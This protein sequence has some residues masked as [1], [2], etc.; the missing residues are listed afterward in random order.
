MRTKLFLGA[1][2]LPATFLSAAADF[3]PLKVKPGLWQVT[4]NNNL[5]GTPHTLTY[6]K[7]ITAKD[8]NTNPWGNGPD[9]KCVWTVVKSSASDMEVHG[10]ECEAGK[11]YGMSTNVDLK[12]HAA[13]AENVKAS[14]DGTSKG[15]GQNVSFSGTYT[16]KW[17]GAGCPAGID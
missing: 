11:E 3:Q 12:I 5:T 6:K 14:M 4:A 16:G 10:A 17:V 15:N 7:C 9:E 8:L 13:D 1:I 2:V